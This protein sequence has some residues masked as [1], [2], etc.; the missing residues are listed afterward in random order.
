MT[1][2]SLPSSALDSQS[3]I[4]S[5]IDDGEKKGPIYA[6]QGHGFSSHNLGFLLSHELDCEVV[7]RVQTCSLP[8]TASWLT[9][10]THL[11]GKI[12]PVFD[13]NK[14][15]FGESTS[16]SKCRY[17]FVDVNNEGF[18]ITIQSMPSRI[19]LTKDQEIQ[20]VSGIP[21]LLIPHIKKMYHKDQIWIDLD[22]KSFFKQQAERLRN[23]FN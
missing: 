10:M 9:G 15:L 21:E 22:Y 1:T 20:K 4:A 3:Q 2:F 18:A 23:S 14:M 19:L 11:R 17:L 8:G 13:L 16:T 12:I 5:H 7:E 6:F